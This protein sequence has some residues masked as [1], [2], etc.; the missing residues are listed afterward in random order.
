MKTGD[1]IENPAIGQRLVLCVS[2]EETGGRSLVVE[3]SY[4]P[5]AGNKGHLAHVHRQYK[6]RFEILSGT[7]RYQVDGKELIA[8]TGDAFDVA[9]NSVHLHP[10][11]D[12]AEELHVRQTTESLKPD[13]EGLNATLIA[14]ETIAGLAHEGKIGANGQP[15]LFQGAVILGS[16]LPQ[17]YTAG[18]PYGVQRVLIGV[19][20]TVGHLLG[21][22]ASYPRF[23]NH[24]AS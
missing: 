1:V 22:R 14:A 23:K 9:V 8:R 18:V 19:L 15:N 3:Y 13:L 11:N 7:A 12:S 4:K 16:L 24:P 5:H 17:S 6:E 21:Y 20:A 10:W 2:P